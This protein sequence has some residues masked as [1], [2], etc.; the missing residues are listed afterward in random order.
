VNGTLHRGAL[1]ALKFSGEVAPGKP[2]ELA[3]RLLLDSLDLRF[4]DPYLPEA[5]SG[6]QGLASGDIRITGK[7]ASPEVAGTALLENAGLRINYL[8]TYYRFTHR[9]NIRPDMFALDLVKAPRR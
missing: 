6:I 3:L 9:V 5:I 4:L 1:E 2:Q 7:L 8:N